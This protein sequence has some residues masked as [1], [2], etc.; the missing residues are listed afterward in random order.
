MASVDKE[1]VRETFDSAKKRFQEQVDAGH[2]SPALHA[3]FDSLIMVLQILIAVFMEK[4]TKKTPKNSSLSPAGTPPDDTSTDNGKKTKSKKCSVTIAPNSRTIEEVETICVT[5]CENCGQDLSEVACGC[6][7]RRTRIDILFEKK[8]EHFDSETKVC[9][10][11]QTTNKAPFP[12][13]VSGKLQYGSGVK[14]YIINLLVAQMIPLRRTAQ[15]LES[16]LG[17]TLSPS[18]L[19]GY[20]SK[21][22]DLLEPWE[23][24]AKQKLLS[25]QCLHTD[26]TSIRVDKKNHWIH[27]YAAGTVTL[28][29]L[30]RKRGKAA[31]EDIG[32]IPL[33]QGVTVHDCW[34]SYLS[35]EHCGHGLCGAHLLRE[36]TFVI[37]AHAYR[38]AKALKK[39]LQRACHQVNVSETKR[40]SDSAYVTLHSRYQAI[41][42]YAKKEMPVPP[43]KPKGKKGKIAKSDAHNLCERLVKYAPSVL[44]FA[45]EP[46]VAFTNNRAERDLRMSKVKQKVSGCFRVERYAQA[47]CRISSYL[48]SMAYEGINPLTA[49]S[50]AFER[51]YNSEGFG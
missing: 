20:I 30:H 51:Q 9:P 26:E 41:L 25:L 24:E 7:E 38:W 5:T 8:V 21:L 15:L 50:M 43:E 31:I 28:K 29:F 40:L 44:L 1:S 42:Q 39:L 11:C 22:H 47:Y 23:T 48:Q 13:G 27:V 3:I 34:A 6:I 10:D 33:Y 18:T 35:Y 2:V 17:Q 36:L 32:I 49:I 46:S 14:A 4:N 19:L 12:A 45:K 37:D 16:M